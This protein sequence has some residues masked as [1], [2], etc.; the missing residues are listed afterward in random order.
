MFKNRAYYEYLEQEARWGL[1]HEIADWFGYTL[2]IGEKGVITMSNHQTLR[3]PNVDQALS[4]WIETVKSHNDDCGK[5]FSDFD[6]YLMEG[7]S[8]SDKMEQAEPNLD[9]ESRLPMKYSY[10][11]LQEHLD[12]M[13]KEEVIAFIISYHKYLFFENDTIFV[14]SKDNLI[15]DVPIPMDVLEFLEKEWPLHKDAD[16]HLRETGEGGLER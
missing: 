9:M 15:P 8:R 1:L 10:E 16:A 3:Y 5:V 14:I 12:A 2:S 4:D 7:I 13:P 11:I 6:L